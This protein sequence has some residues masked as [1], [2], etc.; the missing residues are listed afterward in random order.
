MRTFLQSLAGV[1]ESI[2]G[3][4]HALFFFMAIVLLSFYNLLGLKPIDEVFV[5]LDSVGQLCLRWC[6]N[7]SDAFSFATHCFFSALTYVSMKA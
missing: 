3:L 5:L 7:T 1:S 6:A 4:W 2:T